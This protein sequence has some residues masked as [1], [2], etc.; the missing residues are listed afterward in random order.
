MFSGDAESWFALQVTPRHELRVDAML[1]WQGYGHFLPSAKMRHQWSD[2]IKVIEQPL[3]PGYVFCR[4]HESVLVK[5][6]RSTP[7]VIRAVCF[8]GKPHPVADEEIASLQRIV[9]SERDVSSFPYSTIGQRVQIIAG[10]LTG[11]TGVITEFKKRHRL[12]IS[13]DIIMKSISV[14]IDQSEVLPI[15]LRRNEI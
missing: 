13:L 9:R 12:V 6:A 10:P 3:F 7:G 2:R 5:L 8:G 4:S 1:A 11:I 15:H 14:E